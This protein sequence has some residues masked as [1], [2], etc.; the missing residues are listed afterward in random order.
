MQAEVERDEVPRII[1]QPT[2]DALEPVHKQV[3]R[4]C[5]KPKSSLD[6]DNRNT[7]SGATAAALRSVKCVR[8]I[9]GMSCGT[10]TESRPSH[11]GS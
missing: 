8:Q 1:A 3:T 9:Q 10:E 6:V 11:Y 5:A 7:R 4:T 2:I